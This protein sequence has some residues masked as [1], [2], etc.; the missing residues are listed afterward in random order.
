M[1]TAANKT[2]LT[3][4]RAPQGS[5]RDSSG[6]AEPTNYVPGPLVQKILHSTV[7]GTKR[8]VISN[9]RKI[10]PRDPST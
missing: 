2:I 5:S 4:L 1:D 9:R 10:E 3:M 6:Q 8:L 7:N